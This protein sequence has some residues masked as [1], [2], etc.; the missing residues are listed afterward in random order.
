M[1]ASEA[2]KCAKSSSHKSTCRFFGAGRVYDTA[3]V[4]ICMRLNPPCICPVA[5]LRLLS[6]Q[7]PGS[8]DVLCS[9]LVPKLPLG[10]ALVCEAP[11]SPATPDYSRFQKGGASYCGRVD[12]ASAVPLLPVVAP[13]PASPASRR[14]TVLKTAV[15]PRNGIRHTPA[16]C[17]GG[18]RVQTFPFG[19]LGQHILQRHYPNV[20]NIEPWNFT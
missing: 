9:S 4:C 6:E 5:R 3:F 11:P 7:H 17:S 8:L 18:H 15:T 19:K 10:N 14:S 16:F 2:W 1:L 12:G 13:P 20:G